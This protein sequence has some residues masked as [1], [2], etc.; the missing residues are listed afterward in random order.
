M[1]QS[2]TRRLRYCQSCWLNSGWLRISVKTVVSG[3]RPPITRV[4]VASETPL[5]SARARK[6]STHCAKGCADC[7]ASACVPDASV[8]KLPSAPLSKNRRSKSI[9]ASL[10]PNRGEILPPMDRICYGYAN[11]DA[12]GTHG[13]PHRTPHR[14]S[15]SR[16]RARFDCS[17]GSGPDAAGSSGERILGEQRR[18]EALSLPQTCRRAGQREATGCVPG[19]RLVE[20]VALQL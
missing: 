9:L 3:F 10:V 17:A 8:A 2:E 12:G 13:P 7:C 5:A 4:Y 15:R 19:T 6:V 18:R 16:G 11:N 14:H 20:F 1:R